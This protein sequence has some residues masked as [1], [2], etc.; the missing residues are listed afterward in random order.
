MACLNTLR[1]LDQLHNTL[2]CH[3][4]IKILIPEDDANLLLDAGFQDCSWGCDE[5]PSYYIPTEYNEHG[6]VLHA[7]DDLDEDHNRVSDNITYGVSDEEW[8]SFDNV[9][10][11]IEKYRERIKRFED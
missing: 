4:D 7:I 10:D 3:I 5:I 1:K 11:A 2:D 8:F 9:R 6:C